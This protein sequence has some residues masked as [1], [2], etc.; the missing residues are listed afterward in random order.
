MRARIRVMPALLA[1]LAV[2]A[3]CDSGSKSPSPGLTVSPTTATVTAGGAAAPFTA[4][5][6]G[7]TAT[8][9]WAISPA[10]GTLSA[11]TGTTTSYTPPATV[12]SATTVTLTATAGTLTATATITVN[13]AGAA[14]L[15][16][17]PTTA[18]VTAGGAAAPFTATLTGSTATINWAVSPATGT[19]STATGA[20]TNYTPPASVGGVTTVTITATAGT[21]TAT[22][23]ITVNP[24][25]GGTITVNGTVLLDDGTPLAS[26]PVRID[27]GAHA[28]T[29]AANGTFSISGVTTPYNLAAINT[30][31]KVAVVYVGLTRTDPT[32]HL[33]T[34]GGALPPP[35]RSATISGTVE[36]NTGC[37]AGTDPCKSDLEFVSS[38]TGG[39]G[40]ANPATGL[41]SFIP[42]WDGVASFQGTLHLFQTRTNAT[43]QAKSFWYGAKTGVSVTDGGTTTENWGPSSVTA[44]PPATLSGTGTVATGY[45]VLTAGLTL[46]LGNVSFSANSCMSL[47]GPAEPPCAAGPYTVDAPNLTG[48]TL[49]GVVLAQGTNGESVI[50][51][52]T[53]GAANGTGFDYAIQA[54]PSL[55]APADLATGV[56]TATAF[57]WTAFSGGVHE[58]VFDPAVATDPRY[59]VYTAGTSTTIPNLAAL[60][61]SVALPAGATYSWGV[62]GFAPSSINAWASTSG[63]PSPLPN[64][65]TFGNSQGFGFTTQ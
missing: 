55:Q 41:Y 45:T 29:T 54:A 20:S 7:S 22:A 40:T 36:S 16:V 15:T 3:G 50:T 12:A 32:A 56:T 64:P 21:L 8:I 38:V 47:P 17:S 2:A 43:T 6:T 11:A 58:V 1:A 53:G 52:R 13:P 51:I 60:S 39:S 63:G 23:T 14:T 33:P 10:V 62:S 18:T 26:A 35:A 27:P 30:V 37:R 31:E 19:L 24:S 46:V 9:N 4:T 44:L 49:T 61:A 65:V 34:T 42:R 5:L 59:Y 57:S 48:A 28:A 25:G